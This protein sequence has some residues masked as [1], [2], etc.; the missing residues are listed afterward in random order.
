MSVEAKLGDFITLQ[1]GKTYKSKLLNSPGPYLLGLA[2]I[3]RNGGFRTDNLKTYGGD[4]PEALLLRPGDL[5]V[6]LKDVTQSADLLGA[7]AR[8][9][10][11][12]P[13]GRLTQDTVK[14]QFL[15]GAPDPSYIYWL[16]QTPQYRAYCRNHATGTTNLGLSREDFLAFPVPEINRTR[17]LIFTSLD[18]IERKIEHNRRTAQK[19]EELAHA[20]FR[21]WF[22]DFEPVKAKAAGAQSFPSMPQSVFDALPTSFTDTELGPVPEGW[23]VKPLSEVVD[24]TM[25]QSPSSEFYNKEG[26]GLPFH[27]GVS[28]YGFRFPKHRVYC[29]VEGRLAEV[30]DILLSVRAP[31]GRINVAD[32]RLVLGR[33]LA[34]LRSKKDHQSFLLQQLRYVFEEEDSIG[35]GT[36]YKAVTK[37]F[38]SNMPLLV[39]ADSIEQAFEDLVSFFDQQIAAFE[40]EIT[41]LSEMRDY[42]LPELLSGE[43]RVAVDDAASEAQ[44]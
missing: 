9:P 20:I 30:G 7:I 11:S 29:T 39:P 40:G 3:A 12:I 1:R 5:F 37:K 22:I 27:Q 36:I 44:E 24:L 13:L 14:L 31:V 23:E 6:S 4:S 32:R 18:N 41:K 19:L 33:G 17:E 38:L 26:E 35:D 8:V 15:E 25:G 34:G 43:V 16:L 42:L 10:E 28:N 2:S 21:A